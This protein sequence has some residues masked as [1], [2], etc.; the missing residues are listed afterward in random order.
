[1]AVAAAGGRLFVMGGYSADFQARDEVWIYDPQN[2]QWLP[3][4]PIPEPRGAAWAVEHGGMIYLFGGTNA[5]GSATR[6]T[7]IYDPTMNMWSSGSDMP[8]RR[9]HLNA[10]STGPYIYVIG[11][12]NGPSTAANERYNPAN[13]SWAPLAPMPTARSATVLGAVAGFIY[14]AGGEV[15]NLFAVNE[16]YNITS[17]QWDTRAPMVVPRHGV[18]A[19]SLADN[20][21]A[22]GGGTVQGLQPTTYVDRFVPDPP[23]GVEDAGGPAPA[24]PAVLHANL[25][26]PF[27]RFTTIG[28]SLGAPLPVRLTVHDP[29]GRRV[30]ELLA[31]G[32]VPGP[33][34]LGWDGRDDAGVTVPS[35]VYFIRLETPS[36]ITTRKLVLTR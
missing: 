6:T 34:A 18:A 9:E 30:R 2:P 17:N 33:H 8:T 5:A 7:F 25:P 19:V 29:Q 22:P 4:A 15:P 24:A 36:V 31:A 35:G 16:A 10:V 27:A 13:N 23:S 1:M 28:F 12:R 32:L 11:G 26:N 14:A 3:G 20:I 21:F